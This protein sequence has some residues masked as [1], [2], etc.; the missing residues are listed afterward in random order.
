MN[1]ILNINMGKTDYLTTNVNTD[2][3]F[4]HIIIKTVEEFKYHR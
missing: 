2:A 4:D 3:I 1:V